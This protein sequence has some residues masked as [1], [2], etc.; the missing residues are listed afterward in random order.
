MD[1][2]G[3][4]TGLGQRLDRLK[5]RP[6]AGPSTLTNRPLAGPTRFDLKRR[7][8]SRTASASER[9]SRETQRQRPVGAVSP[10][11]DLRAGVPHAGPLALP[12]RAARRSLALAVLMQA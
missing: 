10:R 7:A 9:W 3:E 6:L 8:C 5:D 1:G 4:A 11:R 2:P 12:V